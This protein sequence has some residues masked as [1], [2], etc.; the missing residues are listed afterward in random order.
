MIE[1]PA[2]VLAIDAFASR[3]DF[4]SI[5]TN[6]LI[7][8]TLAVDR[9]D[10]SVS[11]LYD[12]THPGGAALAGDGDRWCAQGRQVPI[13]VCGEMAGDVAMTRLLLGLGLE[14]FLDAPRAPV[15]GQAARARLELPRARAGGR[16]GS[17]ARTILPRSRRC[18]SAS[19]PDAPAL[20]SA[21]GVRALRGCAS[22]SSGMASPGRLLANSLSRRGFMLMS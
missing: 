9:A 3:L 18:W 13:A 20:G 16:G 15:A 19:T 6:D 17:A 14:Q 12:P 10:D 4:L 22:A 7:Q 21:V 2:A 5:G 1:I 8:Y 11:H